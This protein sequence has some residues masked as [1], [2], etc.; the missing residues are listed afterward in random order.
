MGSKRVGPDITVESYE[1]IKN[2]AKAQDRSMYWLLSQILNNWAAAYEK[3][4][5]PKAKKVV[6]QVESAFDVTAAFEQVWAL[7]EKK[8]NRKTSLAKFSKLSPET[9]QLIFDH[10]PKYFAEKTDK[11]YRYNFETYINKEAWNDEIT[12]NHTTPNNPASSRIQRRAS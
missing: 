3:K 6:A 8:G 12:P 9:M 11:Q 7:Y 1:I 10:I 5:K 4:S 2:A